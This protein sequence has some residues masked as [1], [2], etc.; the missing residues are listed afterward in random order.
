VAA[1]TA[2]LEVFLDRVSGKG[3]DNMG[4]EASSR[5]G[6]GSSRH[7]SGS[8]RSGRR[9]HSSNSGSARGGFTALS[10]SWDDLPEMARSDTQHYAP[11]AA[12]GV[13]GAWNKGGNGGEHG[14]DN[15]SSASGRSHRARRASVSRGS[16]RSEG[17]RAKSDGASSND[18]PDSKNST[19]TSSSSSS[20]SSNRAKHGAKRAQSSSSL[21]M[22]AQFSSTGAAASAGTGVVSGGGGASRDLRRSSSGNGRGSNS[23][24]AEQDPITQELF[25]LMFRVRG[26]LSRHDFGLLHEGLFAKARCGTK[27]AVER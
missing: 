26:G 4:A 25:A 19:S 18:W 23:R 24:L 12:A 13:G 21:K 22:E 2:E 16:L 15:S 11:A 20:S 17:G 27:R 7:R 6:H 1:R 8:L 3:H 9:G 14:N 5:N 10:S